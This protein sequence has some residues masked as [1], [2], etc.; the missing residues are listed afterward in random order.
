MKH[1]P[2]RARTSSCRNSSRARST[3]P[4]PAPPTLPSDHADIGIGLGT[5]IHISELAD[6]CPAPLR[7]ERA[8]VRKPADASVPIALRSASSG[9]AGSHEGTSRR[10]IS[11]GSTALSRDASFLEERQRSD[12]AVTRLRRRR[13]TTSPS[14][15]RAASRV[16]GDRS[17]QQRR[18]AQSRS[19]TEPRVGC[20]SGR[21]LFDRAVPSGPFNTISVWRRTSLSVGVSGGFAA[22][23]REGLARGITWRGS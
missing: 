23:G 16:P 9:C 8:T 18:Q 17:S 7:P 2:S 3:R 15:A 11:S 10:S 5:T 1:Q 19:A 4:R 6:R 22:A 14:P 12:R 20:P 13:L 21:R